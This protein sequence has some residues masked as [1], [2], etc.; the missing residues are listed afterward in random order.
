MAGVEWVTG[1]GLFL[2]AGCGLRAAAQN[3]SFKNTGRLA[4]G[5][6]ECV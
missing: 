3:R 1:E 2:A 6:V 4:F 5:H